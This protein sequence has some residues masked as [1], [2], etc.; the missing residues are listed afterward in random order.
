MNAI[1]KALRKRTAGATRAC[2][3]IESPAGFIGPTDARITVYRD[4]AKPKTIKPG[5]PVYVGDV[6]ES[7]TASAVNVTVIGMT[8]LSVGGNGRL[9]VT[10]ARETD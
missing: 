2:G 3:T 10:E 7:D 1:T 5:D 6:L 4:D 9:V 8:T